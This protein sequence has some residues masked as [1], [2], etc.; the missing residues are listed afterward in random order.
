[1]AKAVS[2]VGES[3]QASQG[4]LGG[5]EWPP[6]QGPFQIMDAYPG[7]RRPFAAP[8]PGCPAALS[9]LCTMSGASSSSDSSKLR[10]TRPSRGKQTGSPPPRQRPPE[11]GLSTRQSQRREAAGEARTANARDTCRLADS[12][13]KVKVHACSISCSGGRRPWRRMPAEQRQHH[14]HQAGR[15]SQVLRLEVGIGGMPATDG[16]PC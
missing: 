8:G 2:R 14:H 10:A 6:R 3:P 1:M 12:P 9:R 15:A 13:R 16:G 5:T 7:R 4:P 11:F